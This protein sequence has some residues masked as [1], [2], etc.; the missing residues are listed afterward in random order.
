MPI[1]SKRP[2]TACN[3]PNFLSFLCRVSAVLRKNIF[4][5]GVAAMSKNERSRGASETLPMV[6]A[7]GRGRI[8][9]AEKKHVD[10]GN[11]G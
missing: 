11:R 1:F 9:I 10:G 5:S 2:G 7:C 8:A 4:D 6:L 3:A